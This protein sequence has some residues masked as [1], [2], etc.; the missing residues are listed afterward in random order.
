MTNNDLEQVE[1]IFQLVMTLKAED[2]AAYLNRACEGD[3]ELR[4]EVESLVAAYEGSNGFLD[5][6]AVT[7]AMKLLGS[8]PT[9]S[10]VGQEVGPYR[11]L[12]SLGRGGMGEVYL[13]EDRRLNRKVALKFLSGEFVTDNWAKRQLIKEAQAVAR[14]DHPN[15]SAVYDFE[16]V[17]DHNFI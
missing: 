16:E 3:D 11:I 6:N 9:D 1:N 12:S 5:E 15:I 2:R 13:A 17:G 8:K 4:Q 14:L 7:L 10:M